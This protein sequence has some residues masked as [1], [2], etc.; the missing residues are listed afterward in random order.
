MERTRLAKLNAKTIEE[1]EQ[2]KTE[3]YIKFSDEW[4]ESR[5]TVQIE[6]AIERKKE[7]EALDNLPP[8][9]DWQVA[10]LLSIIRDQ[11]VD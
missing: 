11:G 6:E 7:A 1:L 3:S 5:E 8:V 9:E 2:L 10:A 4:I